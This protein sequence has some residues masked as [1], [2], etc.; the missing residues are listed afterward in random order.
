MT[1]TE[2]RLD[3]DANVVAM[4][5]Q[6]DAKVL[7]QLTTAAK[8]GQKSFVSSWKNLAVERRKGIRPEDLTTLKKLAEDNE[9]EARKPRVATSTAK[10]SNG[11]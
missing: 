5:D 4:P 10:N 9:P 3:D 6:S 7:A 1:S 8:K 2:K 11:K